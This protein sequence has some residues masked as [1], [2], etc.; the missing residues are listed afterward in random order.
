MVARRRSNPGD[1]H[2]LLTEHGA[3]HD[4]ALDTTHAGLCLPFLVVAGDFSLERFAKTLEG[5]HGVHIA[6]SR[7]VRHMHQEA[8]AS[9]EL[10]MQDKTL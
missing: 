6:L 5:V 4:T 8:S 9:I 7:P 10:V 1:K 3:T 2:Q